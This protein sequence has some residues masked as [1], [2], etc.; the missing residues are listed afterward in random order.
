MYRVAAA[1][2]GIPSGM[3][4]SFDYRSFNP[5]TAATLIRLTAEGGGPINQK[6]FTMIKH[7]PPPASS[8]LRLK[9]TSS[10]AY[11]AINHY[12]NPATQTHKPKAPPVNGTP[13]NVA[14]DICRMLDGVQGLVDQALDGCAQPIPVKP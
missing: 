6:S 4:G 9:P 8:R 11:R 5:R 13:R 1:V 3:P 12:L 2:R 7:S 10:C 14:L